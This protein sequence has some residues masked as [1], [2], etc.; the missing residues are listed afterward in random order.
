MTGSR[1]AGSDAARRGSAGRALPRAADRARSGRG[2]PAGD[3]RAPAVPP[4]TRVHDRRPQRR[5]SLRRTGEGHRTA[6][7]VPVD[8]PRRRAAPGALSAGPPPAAASALGLV[9]AATAL[10]RTAGVAL[11]PAMLLALALHRRWKEATTCAVALLAPLVAWQAVQLY[12]SVR[13][14][15]SSQPDDL[16]YG[17]WL[18]V[19]GPVALIG[20]AVR[21]IA[22]NVVVYVHRMTAYLFSNQPIGVVVVLAAVVA[23]AVACARL[24]W[25]QTA[26]VLTT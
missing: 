19:T 2:R 18:G 15:L 24:R 17:R 7:R 8:P 11:V 16:S 4:V 1:R 5:R 3:R 21:T 14:P 12:W 26:L 22:A 9:L 20:Y 13:G 23:V 6:R 25:S 10:F